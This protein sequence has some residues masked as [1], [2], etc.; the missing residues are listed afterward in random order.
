MAKP[1][2][3]KLASLPGRFSSLPPRYATLPKKV[4]DFY[5]TPEWRKL[6]DFAIRRAG[7]QCEKIEHGSRC[8]KAQPEHRIYID[9]I[10]EIRDGGAK[11]DPTNVQALCP[12]HHT[13]KTN[14]ERAK[15]NVW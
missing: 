8:H 6:R 4:D 11:L 1:K 12:E 3:A 13:L 5:G 15:R 7:G 14:K 2:S 9:H 10:I